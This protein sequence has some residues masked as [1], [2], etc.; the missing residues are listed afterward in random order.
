MKEL[1]K[2]YVTLSRKYKNLAKKIKK[3]TNH[4]NDKITDLSKK[5]YELF[6]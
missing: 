1:R 4:G 6:H 3:T 2:L 5:N